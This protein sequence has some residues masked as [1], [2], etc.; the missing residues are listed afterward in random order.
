M[1]FS[2]TSFSPSWD[3][4]L[5]SVNTFTT[6]LRFRERDF[7]RQTWTEQRTTPYFHVLTCRLLSSRYHPRFLHHPKVLVA[8]KRYREHPPRES[9]KHASASCSLFQYTIIYNVRNCDRI[10]L[11][12]VA[13]PN[14]IFFF[15]FQNFVLAT[16]IRFELSHNASTAAWT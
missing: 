10:I 8:R 16:S 9:T 11:A 15:I 5:V 14:P 6:P 1:T 13:L 3:T 2:S 7:C 4:S 12:P